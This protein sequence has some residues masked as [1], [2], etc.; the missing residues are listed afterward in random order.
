MFLFRVRSYQGQY[1]VVI[2]NIAWKLRIKTDVAIPGTAELDSDLGKRI[3]PSNIR[4]HAGI[5]CA[6][7][8]RDAS[9]E[10]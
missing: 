5:R 8:L 4:K 6:H 7:D 9:T 1:G 10:L 2:I 3:K